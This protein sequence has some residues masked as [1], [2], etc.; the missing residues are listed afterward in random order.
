MGSVKYTEEALISLLKSRDNGAF[1]YLFENY[2]RALSGVIFRLLQ[3]EEMTRDVLQETFVKIWKKI[4]EYDASRGRLYTWMLHIAR[5]TAIDATRNKHFVAA[6]QIQNVDFIVH[7]VNSQHQWLPSTD[8]I[9]V[10]DLLKRLNEDYRML[11]DLAYFQGY[12]QEEISKE[13]N[14]PLGTVKTRIRAALIQ[15]R[16]LMTEN[17]ETIKS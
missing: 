16:K 12:T 2:S 6:G 13:L 5:N 4:P 3:Q 10:R 7:K 9:G 1:E 15:L 17:K 8:H 11:I 14:L